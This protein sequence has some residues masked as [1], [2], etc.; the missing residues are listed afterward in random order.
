VDF[1]DDDANAEPLP[2]SARPRRQSSRRRT[3]V[4][5]LLIVLAVLFV[6]IFLLAWWLRSCQHSRKVEAYRDYMSAVATAIDDSKTLGKQLD[7]IVGDPTQF[8]NGK[9]LLAELDKL[10]AQQDEIAQRAA[11]QEHPDSLADQADVFATGMNVRARGFELFGKAIA[12]A[13][14]KEKSAK[15]GAI[16]ALAGYL[17]GP[18]AYYQ[19]LFYTP[20]RRIMKD[21]DISDVTVPT[22]TFYLANPILTEESVTSMLQ[23]LGASAKLGGVHGVAL[24]GVTAQPSGTALVRG[25]SVPL[26][27]SPDLSFAV[28]VE[29]QGNAAEADVPVEVVLVLPG[30]DKLKQTATIAAISSGTKQTVEV[31]GFAVPNTAISR[32]CTL[33]VKIGPVAEEKVL[34]NNSAT[35]QFLL[36]LK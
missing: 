11:R 10:A 9:A 24:D 33:R 20:A 17:S 3:R 7:A 4:Q 2:P 13:L 14:D 5:R 12:G 15:P 29:N 23:R 18:D 30:G 32:V 25:K 27:A 31:S 22:A 16:A 34:T 8:E 6:V 36:Q 26:P 35:Y 19:T 28:T 1:F 21:D